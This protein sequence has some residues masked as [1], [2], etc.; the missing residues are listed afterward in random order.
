MGM[1]GWTRSAR[2]FVVDDGVPEEFE[3]DYWS[4][5][6]LAHND[7]PSCGF[8]NGGVLSSDGSVLFLSR[9]AVH[10]VFDLKNCLQPTPATA[11]LVAT[12][13]P[14]FPG[15]TVT[16][17]DTSTGRVDRWALWVTKEPGGVLVAGNPTP[18]ATNPHEI[19]FQID[20][21][22]T[23]DAS[24]VAHI[25]VQ[26]D[27]LA[28]TDPDFDA[29]ITIDRA[30]TVTMSVD[31][32]TVIVD[33]KVSLLATVS[34]G[35]PTSYQWKIWKPLS[36]TPASYDGA[37]VPSLLLDI[38][39]QWKFAGVL[40]QTS[41]SRPFDVKS[42]AADFTISPASPLHTQEIVLDG[43]ISKPV[44]GNLSYKWLVEGYCTYDDCP[45][46]PV[47]MI[48]AESLLPDTT[49]NITLTVTNNEDLETDE[50]TKP[51]AVGNGNVQ[52]TISFS[53]TNPNI[54]Q[55][56]LFKIE[57]VPTDIDKASWSMGAT[58]CAAADPTP[59]CTPSLWNDCKVQNYKYA[60]HGTRT[61]NLTIE[62]GG[63][64]FVAPPATITIAPNGSCSGGGG[65]CS[66]SLTPPSAT[67]GTGGG[68]KMFQVTTTAGCPWT[69]A[70]VPYPWLEITQPK[71]TH[72][73][74]G[75]VRYKIDENT[76]PQR[77]GYIGVAGSSFVVTQR[78]PDVPV[79]F[80]LSNTH[81][82]KGEVVT[83]S[84][85]PILEV[86][87]WNFGEPNCREHSPV[88]NCTFLP[89]GTCNTMQ[90]TF[91]T[92]GQKNIEMVVADGRSK[93]R[94]PI[95]LNEGECCFAT[96]RPDAHFTM[97]ND[98]IYTGE[99]VV[100]S[101][102]SSKSAAKGEKAFGFTW[103]PTVPEIGETVRFDIVGVTGDVKAEWDF[104]APGC[105]G[106]SQMQTCNPLYSNCH[107][108]G[109]AYSSSGDMTVNLTVTVDGSVIGTAT[110]TVTVANVG[111]CDDGGGVCKYTLS[112]YSE[113]FPPE[114]GSGS[115]SV[116]TTP[117]CTWTATT[118][119]PWLTVNSGGGTGSGVVTY[120][121]DANEGLSSRASNIKAGGKTFRVT[122]TADAGNTAPTSWRWTITRVLNEDG[123]EVEED[124]F[125]SSEQHMDYRF[126]EP[127]RYRVMLIA[128][129]CFG[130]D[131]TFGY[132][133]VTEV[134]VED[135]VVG[136]AVSS[137]NGANDTHWESDLR[138]Y[139]PCDENLDVRIEYQPENTHNTDVELVFAK[140]Q[141]A[142]NETRVFSHIT[143]A[144]PGLSDDPLSG[145]VRIESTSN[146]GCKVLSVSRTFNDTPDG[147][148]GLFVPALPVK[149]V[150]LE[151]LD[152]TGLIHNQSYRTN[153]RL[154]NYS[155]EEVWV[156]LTAHD[157][158]GDQVGN[159]RSVK[160]KG[161]STKQINGIAEWLGV[162]H[163]LA[164]FS[165][166]GE[167]SGL[168]VQ[169]FGTVVDNT[170]GDSVLYLSSF[171]DENQIWLA[172]V[173]SVSGFNDSQWR[174]DLWLYNP[175]AD[176]LPGEIE[177]VVGDNPGDSYG[178][179]WPTLSENRTKQYLDVVSN[180]LGL[181]ETRGYIVLTGANGGPAPQ[182]AARTFN[183]DSTGGTYGLNLRAFGSK[184]LLQPGE[185]GYIA[186]V[187]NS[188][189]KAV[190]FRT[191]V[192]ILNTDRDGW[193]T[194]RIT[195][196]NLDGSQ[197]AEPFE[198]TIAPGK[199]RQFDIFKKFGL[200]GT[201]ITGS[202]MIEAVSGGAMAVY[203]TEIDNRTQDSIF[204]PAQRKFQG[205]APQ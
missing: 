66:Y 97:S 38:P 138:F 120:S 158:G 15:D 172:G 156:P 129:N 60:S 17:R 177:F 199:L 35:T 53:P 102:T 83:I 134:P 182:V 40:Y 9:N 142:A 39:G 80:T 91:S 105:D 11:S 165:V 125:S 26:S 181:E 1:V 137:L 103:D 65:G 101:D 184:D 43:S 121:V 153:L 147:S 186:G 33:E 176:W 157:K 13:D 73:G 204:I 77:V 86:A 82:K 114:G 45:T 191:N 25:V 162:T 144:I 18:L 189:D 64:V 2:T 20:T 148:L 173:A 94:N 117:E 123:E 124:Y 190:G 130:F 109:H 22:L 203:A 185:V 108:F 155:D 7:L 111:S 72:Y 192:G 104:G 198:T 48:P 180:Q 168:D 106:E 150:G 5:T 115:F 68:D 98:D 132:V 197:A 151:Y 88:I 41:A 159:R 149:R 194:V 145:S 44:G 193:T 133:E 122:Q 200:G 170:T 141:L 50:T 3:A 90:W 87:S 152:V 34:G 205:L 54:G 6:S 14:A 99:T 131:T 59:E 31:P 183:L 161:Q 4:D 140:F 139:N 195:L 119:S 164:P 171:H 116:N 146:S 69:A 16:V 79:T 84:V 70:A 63:N 128:T 42:V 201:T 57:G 21:N 29:S 202:L 154:V 78:A 24:Y 113:A 169:A 95:V 51:L 93:V 32:E 143:E 47:W 71:G 187:S 100:F 61:V 58:G 196:Y 55:S 28:P 85:N 49:Y 136:A 12:P 174:T 107:S 67:V 178:F 46:D 89:S 76:G 36:L 52:P 96:A 8:E 81:P 166:R 19:S 127:G 118:T 188:E 10:Q 112:D 110:N 126:S 135:F 30:P 160:V 175:T 163:D 62:V 167:V 74:S 179:A 27:D 37:S 23:S 56:V 75:T 92:S